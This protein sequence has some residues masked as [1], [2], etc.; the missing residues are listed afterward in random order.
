MTTSPEEVS[1]THAL[2]TAEQ[3][4]C[5]LTAW[6]ERVSVYVKGAG[7][8]NLK[9]AL[10]RVYAIN[11]SQRTLLSVGIVQGGGNETVLMGASNSVPGQGDTIALYVLNPYGVTT[12]VKIY[13]VGWDP[14]AAVTPAEASDVEG[15]TLTLNEQA[16]CDL[17]GGYVNLNLSFNANGDPLAVGAY[18]RLYAFCGGADLFQLNERQVSQAEAASVGSFN[19]LQNFQAGAVEFKTTAQ[20]RLGNSAVTVTGV[21]AGTTGSAGAGGGGGPPSG[22]YW[23][24]MVALAASI[25]APLLV[26]A[27]ALSDV[28]PQNL[29]VQAQTAFAGATVNQT[30]G[31]LM[32]L[33]GA[34]ATGGG[35]N[36]VVQVG[37]GLTVDGNGIVEVT[38]ALVFTE[39]IVKSSG[40]TPIII[41]QINTPTPS[42]SAAPG[43]LMLNNG[44]SNGSF[45]N[46]Y[47]QN[48]A[49]AW[50]PLAQLDVNGVLTFDPA[51]VAPGMRQAQSTTGAGT[52]FRI[53][54]QQAK[55]G[56]TTEGGDMSF[57]LGCDDPPAEY[58]AL[59]SFFWFGRQTALDGHEGTTDYFNFATLAGNVGGVVIFNLGRGT[60]GVGGGLAGCE[61]SSFSEL[62]MAVENGVSIN[63]IIAGTGPTSTF[64][65]I[66]DHDTT[67]EAAW[68]LAYFANHATSGDVAGIQILYTQTAIGSGTP[69]F[70]DFQVAGVRQF[71]IRP[72][73][74]GGALLVVETGYLNISNGAIQLTM[75]NSF[76]QLAYAGVYGW[77]FQFTTGANT[78]YAKAAVT[79]FALGIDDGSSAGAVAKMAIYG[80]N[81]GGAGPGGTCE[82]GPGTG[83]S[84]GVLSIVNTGTVATIGANG[85]AAALTVLPVGYLP[86]TIGGSAY[87]IPFYN[88]A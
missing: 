9:G 30:G 77:T 52:V 65:N 18:L 26:Q 74:L 22:S 13:M 2:T 33:A 48:A 7:I 8:A 46:L 69:R 19:W 39:A 47:V 71:S 82:I 86:V 21:L 45:N 29:L 49:L 66:T 5:T 58:P 81:N 36:G 6:H 23:P 75:A 43:S 64:L 62:S 67:D 83:G 11:G 50:V 16:L 38:T 60:N 85:G 4:F 3:L 42:G 63:N 10:C 17:P 59:D 84:H 57:I 35:A 31:N 37:S 73:V 79:S 15:V 27:T 88:H 54:S 32:L 34:K 51:T 14:S 80:Q 20:G 61:I 87:Q 25:V 68:S 53:I 40:Y 76:V 41:S 24:T 56:S 12:A 44:G 1:G 78:I 55:T 28:V 70:I 72:Y